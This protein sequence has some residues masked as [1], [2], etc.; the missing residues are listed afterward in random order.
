MNIELLLLIEISYSFGSFVDSSTSRGL[1]III[2][3]I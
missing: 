2:K 1:M 3:Y